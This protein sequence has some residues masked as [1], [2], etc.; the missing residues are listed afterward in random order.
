MAN[1]SGHMINMFFEKYSER[2]IAF[3]KEIIKLIGLETQNVYLKVKGDQW[4]CVV[5]SCSMNSAKVIVNLDA[6]AFAA[7]NLAKNALN[8]R[9]SFFPQDAK[10]SF[11]FFV[12]C[13]VVGYKNFI[14]N[15]KDTFIL[16]LKFAQRPP[17]DLIEIIGSLLNDKENFEKRKD[18]RINLDNKVIEDLGLV[19]IKSIAVMENEKYPCLLRNISASGA[20]VMLSCKPE[21]ILDKKVFLTFLIKDIKAPVQIEGSVTRTDG[22]EGRQD[23]FGVG[24]EFNSGKIPADYKH[25]INNYLDKLEGILKRK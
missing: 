24:I 17:D 18:M 8:L 7:L 25:M 9:L 3:N 10:N 11:S 15:N 20:Y 23:I 12:P 19:S 13:T 5:Y 2:E 4:S 6:Q 21:S 16:S 22:V 1:L 14:G